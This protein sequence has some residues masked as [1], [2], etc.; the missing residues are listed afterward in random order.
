MPR[1]IRVYKIHSRQISG[2]LQFE[3]RDN[4]EWTIINIPRN[5]LDAKSLRCE[6][7]ENFLGSRRIGFSLLHAWLSSYILLVVLVEETGTLTLVHTNFRETESFL[8]PLPNT[9]GS[10]THHTLCVS[11]AAS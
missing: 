10:L 11:A 9:F 2:I 6:L 5:L 1:V 4:S 7:Y 8:S 3:M